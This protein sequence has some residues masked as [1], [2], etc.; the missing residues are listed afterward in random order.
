MIFCDLLPLAALACWLRPSGF[1]RHIAERSCWLQATGIELLK[2][3]LED[4]RGVCAFHTLGF[5][6]QHDHEFLN[7]LT[8]TGTSQGTF[9][10][11]QSQTQISQA[12]TTMCQ[13]LAASCFIPPVSIMLPD[14]NS[15][16]V[17]LELDPD[18]MH[19]SHPEDAATSGCTDAETGAAANDAVE[20]STDRMAAPSEISSGPSLQARNVASTHTHDAAD[21]S[22]PAA[23][24]DQHGAQS[25][26]VPVTGA[27]FLLQELR[28]DSLQATVRPSSI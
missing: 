4:S 17:L 10:Y 20:G 21:T 15:I 7:E 19:D 18:S 2:T 6:P 12:M 28:A 14:G 1:T 22:R 23:P 9:I 8:R 26:A 27:K 5:T 3:T 25:H 11:M 13:L 24:A 16:N